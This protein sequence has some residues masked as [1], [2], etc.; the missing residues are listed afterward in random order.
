[1]A[2]VQ[3]LRIESLGQSRTNF[4]VLTH[5]LPPAAPVDGLLGLDFFRGTELVIDFRN[6]QIDV[7]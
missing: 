7:R 1:M 2:E 5:P 4:P 6:G 3:L